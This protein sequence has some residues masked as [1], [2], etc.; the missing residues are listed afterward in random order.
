MKPTSAARAAYWTK[1][2]EKY[3]VKGK[4]LPKRFCEAL[5]SQTFIN[6][7]V[8]AKGVLQYVPDRS[9][10]AVAVLN[11][12]YSPFPEAL[13]A[14]L[15]V[16]DPVVI[17]KPGTTRRR[18]K[19][20]VPPAGKTVSVRFREPKYSKAVLKLIEHGRPILLVGPAGSGKTRLFHNLAKKAGKQ[21]YRVNFDGGMTPDAFL[22]GVRLRTV[23]NPDG[24]VSQETY[25]QE[26]PVLKAAQEGAWLLLDEIDKI[27]P[28]YAAA[29]HAMLEDV[30]NPITVNDDGG[31]AIIPHPDFRI[32]GAANTLGNMED[33]SLGYY[34]SSPMNAAFK[35]RWSILQVG[36]PPDETSIV[37]DIL[38]NRDLSEGLV[39]VAKLA[40]Q[41]IAE[42]KL[43]GMPFSTRRLIAWASTFKYLGDFDYATELEILGRYTEASRSLIESFISNVFGNAWR[44][45][46]DKPAKQAAG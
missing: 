26:G 18:K 45:L 3:V 9:P 7:T 12:L 41:A 6:Q 17:S 11:E 1:Q 29:L 16:K 14:I 20:V 19:T 42:N 44:S 30:H 35:D 31:R 46:S 22:G 21:I 24:S 36:Y 4:P 15:A 38:K 27:Q 37:N 40:R 32:L 28:E 13:A 10:M 34:G 33:N 2:V 25:F 43:S 39:K 8:S 23:K 5:A